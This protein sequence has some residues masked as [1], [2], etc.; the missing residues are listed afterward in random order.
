MAVAVDGDARGALRGAEGVQSGTSG[1]I[2][3]FRPV[4]R[5]PVRVDRFWGYLIP[6]ETKEASLAKKQRYIFSM[7]RIT[8]IS[9]RRMP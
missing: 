8:E 5:I 9:M 4:L 3:A 1:T 6:Y 2:P 7:P